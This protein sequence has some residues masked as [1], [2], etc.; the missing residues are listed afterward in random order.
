MLYL[1]APVEKVEKTQAFD[2]LVGLA[3]I[4]GWYVLR[5]RLQ[6][7]LSRYYKLAGT[8]C[9]PKLKNYLVWEIN[10]QNHERLTIANMAI[11][12]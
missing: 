4:V 9:R 11:K 5:L 12:Y 10:P 3:C 2:L 1:P 7:S 6:F 8:R